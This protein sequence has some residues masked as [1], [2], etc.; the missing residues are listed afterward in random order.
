MELRFFAKVCLHDGWGKEEESEKFCK[1]SSFV[2]TQKLVEECCC[3]CGERIV[4]CGECT[5][6]HSLGLNFGL[7]PHDALQEEGSLPL[8]TQELWLTTKL[9]K[10]N[11]QLPDSLGPGMSTSPPPLEKLCREL[12][13]KENK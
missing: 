6:P 1:A 7:C 11:K 4:H 2:R 9:A 5:V 12:Q 13:N 8:G 3:I 10:V